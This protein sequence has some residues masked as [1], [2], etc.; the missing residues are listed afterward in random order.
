MAHRF[1]VKVYYE[2]TDAAGIVYYANYLKFLERAR[3]EYLADEGV[4]IAT[5]HAM[6]EFYVVARAEI[7]YR[8][9]ARLGDILHIT[10]DIE[11]LRRASLRLRHLILHG[12]TLIAE[13]R[14]TI[15]NVDSK[16]R[17]HRFPPVFAA[18]A[19]RQRP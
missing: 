8:K 5:R 2:D 15:A 1:E 17:P 10:T 19:A 11:E 9:S 3:T 16:G 13:A 12:D 14:I 18:I 7:D 6:G 4:D